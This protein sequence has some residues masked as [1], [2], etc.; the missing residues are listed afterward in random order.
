MHFEQKFE[1]FFF[2]VSAIPNY[3]E[4]NQRKKNFQKIPKY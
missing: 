1:F 4:I 3:V 2:D